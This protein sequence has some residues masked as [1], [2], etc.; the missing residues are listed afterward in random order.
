MGCWFCGSLPYVE[1]ESFLLN[2]LVI[3]ALAMMCNSLTIAP[4]GT[5]MV[6]IGTLAAYITNYFVIIYRNKPV[7]PA[8]LKA[9][10]TAR[11]VMGGYHLAPTNAMFVSV[12]II[13]VY[14]VGVFLI[15]R[16]GETTSFKDSLRFRGIAISIGACLLFLAFHNP[17]FEN[18]GDFQWE[19]RLLQGFHS[20]G[21][22]YTFVK[23]AQNSNVEKPEGYSR[24][25]VADYLAEYEAEPVTE[26]QGTQP[27]NII[28]VMNEAFSDLR[29]VGLDK[30]I[31][32]MPFVDSLNENVISGN[33]LVSVYGGG[34]CNTEFESLT[35]NSLAFFGLG[36]YPYT[37][38]VIKPLFSLASYFKQRGYVTNAFHA[39]NAAN[40]NRKTVYPNLGFETF[41]SIDD[42]EA[43]GEV[44]VLHTYPADIADY[45]YVAATSEELKGTPR[46]LFD[47][48]VQNHSPYDRW[49]DLQEAE[50]VKQ[51]GADLSFDA[52][53][54]LSLVKASD[55]AIKELVETYRNYDEPTM[56]IFFG[57]HEPGLYVSTQLQIYTNIWELNHFQTKLFIWTNY[58]TEAESDVQISANY[59]PWLILERGNFPL[60]PYV[61]M[62]KE[63]H[64][65]YP[66]ISSQ[67]VVD[68]DGAVYGSVAELAD[69]PLI[70]KYQ[71]VQYANLFD[72]LDA[73]WFT[74]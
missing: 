31:N 5:V 62:L 74:P 3:Y 69:D 48:T 15:R 40:W 17:M 18:M 36:A 63:V 19:N 20:N 64:E 41:Y 39:S 73:A 11:E 43:F 61:R 10:G 1:Y 28:M 25:V 66:V 8:D 37:E 68:A 2:L 4:A 65:K 55:D 45:Q 60:P 44:P 51:N 30:S 49:E 33:L 35:G 70:Q 24:D 23:S 57:D 22:I 50:S 38:N 7:M 67:G 9:I 13:A 29:E 26:P 42:Y 59:L 46:F 27:M 54:Y 12:F 58:G 21:M 72:E 52:K 34:T 16:N 47:V 6:I 71:Y 53:V 32:V 56:I 14:I